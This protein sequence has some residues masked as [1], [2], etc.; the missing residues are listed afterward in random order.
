MNARK[1]ASVILVSLCVSA[2]RL[3]AAS[4]GIPKTVEGERIRAFLAMSEKGDAASA[5]E[6][7][8]K[9]FSEGAR[10]AVPLEQRVERI[11]AMAANLGPLELVRVIAAADGNAKFVAHSKKKGDDLTVSLEL[12]SSPFRGIR[13]VRLEAGGEREQDGPL[14]PA[15]KP[16]GSDREVAA[17]TDAWLA[18]L[19]A[20]DEFSGVVLLA[21]GGTPFYSKAFGLADRERRIPNTLDTKFN[22]ASIGKAF[23]SAAVA[24]LVSEGRLSW[25]DTILHVLPDSKLPSA[26]RIT[27]AQLIE[28][29]SGLGDFFGPEFAAADKRRIRE[30]SD[31]LPLFEK[32][33]LRFEPGRGNEYSNAG[34]VVLGLMIEKVTGKKYRDYVREAVFAPAGMADTGFFAVDEPTPNRATGY[35]RR[36]ESG[37]GGAGGPRRPNTDTLPG[38]GS[39]AGG[40]YSTAGDLLKFAGA[41]KRGELELARPGRAPAAKGSPP[42]PARGDEALAGGSPGTNAVLEA[43]FEKGATIIVLANDDPPIAEKTRR[44]I[45]QWMAK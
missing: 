39:S 45:G 26:D 19:A 29:T 41:L 14:E 33:P 22:I 2:A 20:A 17:A 6:F 28:M 15:E 35:T 40:A 32:K 34:Y 37:P 16:K 4:P 24:K 9:N 3:S 10:K 27:V 25:S 43:D 38:R 42:E 11:V 5:R 8:E 1:I 13:G 44:R 23:T 30:L 21:R 12:E 31:Y 7:V 36:G 18:K